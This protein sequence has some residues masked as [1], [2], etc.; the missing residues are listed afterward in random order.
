MLHAS[1]LLASASGLYLL[2]YSY[3]SSP[4]DLSPSLDSGPGMTSPTQGSDTLGL[5]NVYTLR[6]ADNLHYIFL[7][8]LRKFISFGGS[9]L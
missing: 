9:G 3:L 2:F 4:G 7:E 1:A 5:K 8:N 6:E